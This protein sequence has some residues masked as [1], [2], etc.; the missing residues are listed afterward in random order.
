M[1]LPIYHRHFAEEVIGEVVVPPSRKL[2]DLIRLSELCVDLLRG[3]EEFYAEVSEAI[4]NLSYV[5]IVIILFGLCCR[6]NQ[7]NVHLSVPFPN[8][9]LY[10]DWQCGKR[11]FTYSVQMLFEPSL[12]ASLALCLR[13]LY[14]PYFTWVLN[15]PSEAIFFKRQIYARLGME[16]HFYPFVCTTPLVRFGPGLAN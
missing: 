15:C 4:T 6:S 5:S 9:I 7:P 14:F 11:I 8:N 16:L 2:E 1:L 10:A 12:K 3:N 13:P